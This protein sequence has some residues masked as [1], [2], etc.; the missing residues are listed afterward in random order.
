MVAIVA[1]GTTKPSSPLAY[2]S[3]SL[4]ESMSSEFLSYRLKTACTC[5]SS[6][7]ALARVTMVV[8]VFAAFSTR[9]P[10]SRLQLPILWRSC[11]SCCLA[12]EPSA[13]FAAGTCFMVF[14]C[15]RKNSEQPVANLS[16][17]APASLRLAAVASTSRRFGSLSAAKASA[18][19]LNS[20]RAFSAASTR[21][22]SSSRSFPAFSSAS[23]FFLSSSSFFSSSLRF[24][25]FT[26]STR[27]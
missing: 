24:I 12:S 3:T 11:G 7:L 23:C 15:S 25:S 14:W 22:L 9:V 17:S 2:A 13:G 19:S 5:C 27:F 1:A 10:H 26:W 18:L 8:F 4:R 21:S 20:P 6:S 16:T